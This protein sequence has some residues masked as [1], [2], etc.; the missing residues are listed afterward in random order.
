MKLS[1]IQP[2][3]AIA[4]TAS[5]SDPDLGITGLKWQWMRTTAGDAGS[6]A[7]CAPSG[8]N[9]DGE[10]APGTAADAAYVKIAGKTTDRYTPGSGDVGKCLR[11]TATYDDK[12]SNKD[13]ENTPAIDES[14][15]TV[16]QKTSANPVRAAVSPNEE[17]KFYKGR[18]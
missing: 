6:P 15:P 2:E 1:H 12:V 8:T 7:D 18:H 4:L 17:P 16:W 3:N 14:E 5:H 13:R 10:V 11:V 9:P